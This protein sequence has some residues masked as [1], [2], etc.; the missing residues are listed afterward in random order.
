MEQPKPKTRQ[1]LLSEKIA[2]APIQVILVFCSFAGL[3]GSI[4]PILKS[5]NV[6]DNAAYVITSLTTL[7]VIALL[8]AF[9][10]SSWKIYLV[11]AIITLLFIFSLVLCGLLYWKY[12]IEI[13]EWEAWND[14]VSTKVQECEKEFKEEEAKIEKRGN[15][16]E[17][18]SPYYKVKTACIG[19]AIREKY[20]HQGEEAKLKISSLQNDIRAGSYLMSNDTVFEVLNT[21]LGVKD[22]FI[23]TGLAIPTGDGKVYGDARFPEYL[24]PNLPEKGAEILT[25]Q[26]DQ[27]VKGLKEITSQTVECLI[28]GCKNKIPPTNIN[29]EVREEKDKYERMIG[30]I[31]DPNNRFDEGNIILVRFNRFDKKFYTEKLGREEADWVFMLR[32][33]D[34]WS[35][36]IDDALTYSGHTIEDAEDNKTIFVWVYISENTHNSRIPA[37]WINIFNNLDKLLK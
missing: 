6:S 23:G 27:K 8:L 28:V 16:N 9:F 26:I 3:S 4:F 12:F 13:D 19:R 2:S 32:L 11:R 34:V 15:Y 36:S 20:P 21:K 30:P 17:K 1:Q 18:L 10:F 24:V 37:T 5:I 31:K 35:M 7:V 29:L 33:R 14:K 22:K 25:W